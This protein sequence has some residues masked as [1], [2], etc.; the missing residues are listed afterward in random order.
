MAW[1]VGAGLE[2]K[3]VIVTG[4]AGGIGRK[5]AEAFA[6][7]GARVMAVDLD[8]QAV[9]AVVA[10]MEG[11]GHKAVGPDLR[12]LAVHDTLAH[13]PRHEPGSAYVVAHHPTVLRAQT[14]TDGASEP[15]WYFT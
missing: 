4:A 5:V 2:G 6:T 1:S 13:R 10:S 11:E 14:N 3:G 12:N 7:T 9:E 8:Q 15:V